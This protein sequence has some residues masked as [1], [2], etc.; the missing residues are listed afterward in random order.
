M[1]LIDP[2]QPLRYASKF[3]LFKKKTAESYIAMAKVVTEAKHGL[4]KDQY[5]EF[6]ALIGYDKSDSTIAK[7]YR[8][9]LQA[10]IFEQYID[11]L[12]ASFTTL[13]A[14]TTAGESMLTT[15]FQ[16]NQI[17]PSL[18]GS[19]VP[20]LIN[21]QSRYRRS[22][23]SSTAD[24]GVTMEGDEPLARGDGLTI[25]I[26]PKVSRDDL[27]KVL[28]ELE[29]LFQRI[30]GIKVYLPDPILQRLRSEETTM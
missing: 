13:Y 29:S 3:N 4:S 6:I 17:R 5:A 22:P 16:E 15:L 18:R 25:Q 27:I 12:P 20:K 9:G 24:S 19:E 30:D 23:S 1:K 26:L 28:R 2:Q 11:R 14:L 10:D 7:L 8:I 21:R